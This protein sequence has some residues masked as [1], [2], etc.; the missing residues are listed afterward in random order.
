MSGLPPGLPRAEDGEGPKRV[1][2]AEPS[3]PKEID[4]GVAFIHAFINSTQM[5]AAL[6]LQSA[7]EVRKNPKLHNLYQLMQAQIAGMQKSLRTKA[8]NHAW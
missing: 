1:E 3:T 8:E 6:L 7:H 2:L 4:H 5:T